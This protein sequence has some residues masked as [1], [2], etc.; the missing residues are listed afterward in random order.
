MAKQSRPWPFRLLPVQNANACRRS[1][2][3]FPPNWQTESG[4]SLV[5]GRQNRRD[6]YARHEERSSTSADF[7]PGSA[8]LAEDLRGHSSPHLPNHRYSNHRRPRRDWPS[9][10]CCLDRCARTWH[11]DSMPTAVVACTATK[12]QS[13]QRC[14][15]HGSAQQTGL[16][17][18]RC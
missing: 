3:S 6:C 16:S 1:R 11:C 7:R 5:R 12:D 13:P 15:V 9:E 8:T 17:I 10:R 14:R 2:D 18:R 4:R